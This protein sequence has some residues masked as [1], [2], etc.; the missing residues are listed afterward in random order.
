MTIK[1][2]CKEPWRIGRPG[3]VVS[4]DRVPEISGADA[5]EHYGGH[6]ICESVA[7]RNAR[8][9]VACVNACEGIGTEYLEHFGGASFNAFK[10]QKERAERAEAVIANLISVC[11]IIDE[12]KDDFVNR[13][14]RVL[15]DGQDDGVPVFS[16]SEK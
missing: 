13:V 1:D 12:S 15:F 8:R 10:Q 7:E 4:D 5:V 14:R 3:C 11:T 9:I 2:H 6:L 16:R